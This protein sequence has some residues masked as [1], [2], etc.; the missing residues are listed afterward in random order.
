LT[1]CDALG[2]L[3]VNTSSSTGSAIA[4]RSS[5]VNQSITV[6]YDVVG[7]IT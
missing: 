2:T 6:S 3:Y 1:M 4:F 7:S 5:L